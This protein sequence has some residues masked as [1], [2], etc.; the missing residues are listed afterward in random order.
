MTKS[1]GYSSERTFHE[2]AHQQHKVNS[3]TTIVEGFY[4]D[5]NI[6]LSE[7]PRELQEG[8]DRAIA[9]EHPKPPPTCLTFGKYRTGRMSTLEDF[10][11][12]EWHGEEEFDHRHGQ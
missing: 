8:R 3:M 1:K 2:L 9:E 6:E 5:G 7:A 10:K 11:Q 4:R 12:A